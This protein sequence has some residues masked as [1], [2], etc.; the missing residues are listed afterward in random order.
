MEAACV[1]QTAHGGGVA[2]L[3]LLGMV[4]YGGQRRGQRVR[5]TEYGSFKV[6][7][8]TPAAIIT[9]RQ[10]DSPWGRLFPGEAPRKGK[11]R[12][13]R[14]F[15]YKAKTP[16]LCV[17]PFPPPIS[18]EVEEEGGKGSLVTDVDR[19]R[20]M[21]DYLHRWLTDRSARQQCKSSE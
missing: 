9:Q 11:Q 10:E 12:Y 21:K 16:L 5:Q 6:A 4:L 20:Y 15:H 3:L 19:K 8:A 7:V 18:S 13:G 17:C 1:S 2:S 14:P